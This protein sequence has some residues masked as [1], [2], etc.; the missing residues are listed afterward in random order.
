MVKNQDSSQVRVIG[1]LE[2][3]ARD[4][5]ESTREIL[6]PSD[7]YVILGRLADAQRT[8]ADV[9]R[10]LAAWHAQVEH[11]VHHGGEHEGSVLGSPGWVRAELAL[12]EAARDAEAAA[13]AL[14]RAESANGV[15]RW[16]DEIKVDEL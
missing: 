7:S 5:A 13:D 11:G 3:V 9:Y 6:R 10:Q 2:A 8:M 15:A 12:Q 4:V 1:K 14:K 16:Y